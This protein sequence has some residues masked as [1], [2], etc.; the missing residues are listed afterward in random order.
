[1]I[2]AE[3]HS[4]LEIV[5][6]ADMKTN[7]ILLL[8]NPKA[9]KGLFLQSLPSVIDLFT[10]AGFGVEVYPTQASGDAV[11]KIMNLEDDYYMIVPAGETGRSMKL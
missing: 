6:K 3:Y 1:M 7:R 9:G 4:L 5:G 2:N 11:R 10:K 8:Y